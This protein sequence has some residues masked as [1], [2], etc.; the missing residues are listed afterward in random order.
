MI[1]RLSIIDPLPPDSQTGGRQT[2]DNGTIGT[3][4]IAVMRQKIVYS[5]IGLK[6][7]GTVIRSDR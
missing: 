3:Y 1:Q 7:N 5:I 4:S 2:E 6:I